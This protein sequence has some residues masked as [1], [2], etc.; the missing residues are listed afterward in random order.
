MNAINGDGLKEIQMELLVEALS[1]PPGF[2]EDLLLDLQIGA[3]RS[4]DLLWVTH[5]SEILCYLDEMKENGKD[6]VKFFNMLQELGF[7][8]RQILEGNIPTDIIEIMLKYGLIEVEKHPNNTLDTINY[9]LDSVSLSEIWSWLYDRGQTPLQEK[10]RIFDPNR[11]GILIAIAARR[12]Y[13]PISLNLA[14]VEK[15]KKLPN[16]DFF[17]VDIDDWYEIHGKFRREHMSDWYSSGAWR[18]YEYDE[19]RFIIIEICTTCKNVLKSG[20]KNVCDFCNKII[21][22][23]ERGCRDSSFFVRLPDSMIRWSQ[24]VRQRARIRGR[25]LRS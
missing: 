13:S 8:P 18:D 2:R 11:I 10:L 19:Q 7:S 16:L 20:H 4:R 23:N 1:S 22:E 6:Q 25:T 9:N 15:A 3:E 24:R 14:L 21:N 12:G 17:V 5:G